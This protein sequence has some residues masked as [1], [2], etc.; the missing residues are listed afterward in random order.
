MM[1]QVGTVINNDH[2]IKWVSVD[3]EQASRTMMIKHNLNI[4]PLPLAFDE[5]RQ[6]IRNSYRKLRLN[7]IVLPAIIAV[8]PWPTAWKRVKRAISTS[9]TT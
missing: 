4:V 3:S 7:T 6:D 2:V 8:R 1:N 5:S 9:L